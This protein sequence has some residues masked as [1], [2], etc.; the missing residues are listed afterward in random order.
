MGFRCHHTP[1]DAQEPDRQQKHTGETSDHG[2]EKHDNCHEQH[3]DATKDG[4][5]KQPQ[6]PKKR[7]QEYR[8][9]NS[10]GV[11]RLSCHRV[12]SRIMAGVME[13]P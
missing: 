9:S 5:V 4:D 7:H 12:L 6:W 11:V 1:Q 2:N 3:H 13:L 10:P 8:E